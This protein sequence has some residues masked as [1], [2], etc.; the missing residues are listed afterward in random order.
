M[1]VSPVHELIPYLNFIHTVIVYGI[2]Q[3]SILI[4]IQKSFCLMVPFVKPKPVILYSAHVIYRNIHAEFNPV[5]PVNIYVCF[6]AACL[7]DL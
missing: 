7:P 6:L 2:C 3:T 1:N 5:S 4:Q